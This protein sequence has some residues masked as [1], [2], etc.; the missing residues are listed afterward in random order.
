MKGGTV[1]ASSLS[2]RAW[3]ARPWG[4]EREE[5]AASIAS[6]RG[7]GSAGAAV[8]RRIWGSFRSR[9]GRDR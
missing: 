1:G 4:A 8:A 7:S 9:V 2:A 6:A 5:I 3:A